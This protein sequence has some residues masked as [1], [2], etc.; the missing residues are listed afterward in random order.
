MVNRG[1][2]VF[3][4]DIARRH[5]DS[6]SSEA[7]KQDKLVALYVKRAYFHR[8]SNAFKRNLQR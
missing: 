7:S 6:D 1:G 5:I 8:L 3:Q 2:I 4:Q